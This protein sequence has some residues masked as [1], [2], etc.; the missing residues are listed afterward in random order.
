MKSLF[1]LFLIAS[2]WAKVPFPETVL[3]PNQMIEEFRG[4]LR[5]KILDLEKNYYALYSDNTIVYRSH[6]NVLCNGKN[7]PA[8]SNLASLQLLTKKSEG[9]V[10]QI[11]K[12]K[13]CDDR[14]VITEIHH[15]EGLA[16]EEI[17]FSQVREGLTQI[18]L[19]KSENKRIYRLVYNDQVELFQYVQ[20][21]TADG[22]FHEARIAGQ[23]A[24]QITYVYGQDSSR[25]TYKYFPY[26][27]KVQIGGS[28]WT[29][30]MEFTPYTNVVNAF[31]TPKDYVTYF[32]STNSQVSKGTFITNFGYNIRERTLQRVLSFIQASLNEFPPTTVVNTGVQNQRLLEELRL[33]YTRLLNN[34]EMN[35]VRQYITDLIQAA[36]KGQLQDNRPQ[37]N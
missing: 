31:K 29:S 30:N 19:K 11:M 18:D 36:E 5:I 15:A 35:L 8:Q 7:A 17:S 3:T 25:L 16:P 34:S 6:Q 20:E 28:E 26:N 14:V 21:R 9:V 10:D 22:E 1:A 13:G 2:A 4:S 12:Y 32:D 37:G 23:L 24:F 27:L 33:N